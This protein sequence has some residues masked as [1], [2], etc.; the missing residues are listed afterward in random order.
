MPTTACRVQPSHCLISRVLG[1][2]QVRADTSPSRALSHF[3]GSVT[4][5]RTKQVYRSG[6]SMAERGIDM[7]TGTWRIFGGSV[8]KRQYKPTCRD[9]YLEYLA[10]CVCEHVRRGNGI[11]RYPPMFKTEDDVKPVRRGLPLPIPAEHCLAT[12]GINRY[13][14]K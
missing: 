2:F 7:R 1:S 5:A 9:K 12:C 6:L 13:F 8:F 10:H 11:A 14:V 3:Q 4:M